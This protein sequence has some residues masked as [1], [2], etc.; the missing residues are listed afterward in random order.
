MSR[1]AV[2]SVLQKTLVI[3]IALGIATAVLAFVQDPIRQDLP[4]P[5]LRVNTGLVLMSVVDSDAVAEDTSG[6]RWYV[7]GGLGAATSLD[8]CS[9]FNPGFTTA[10]FDKRDCRIELAAFNPIKRQ[11]IDTLSVSYYGTKPR[12]IE[13]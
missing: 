6:G 4:A 5:V 9:A 10:R 2:V 11:S 12:L 13:I 7:G 8:L 1:K 3:L